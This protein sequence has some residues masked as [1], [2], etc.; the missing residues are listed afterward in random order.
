MATDDTLYKM[1]TEMANNPIST[2]VEGKGTW[3]MVVIMAKFVWRL[4]DIIAQL[5]LFGV[6]VYLMYL[7]MSHIHSADEVGYN[8]VMSIIFVLVL[9]MIA[10]AIVNASAISTMTTSQIATTI[11]PI[12]G[13]ILFIGNI[14][15]ILSNAHGGLWNPFQNNMVLAVQNQM[16]VE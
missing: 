11:T 9:Q 15:Q 14:P 7:I 4:F 1:T 10:S 3:D 16:V 6:L 5:V 12:K 8:W 13:L 2:S